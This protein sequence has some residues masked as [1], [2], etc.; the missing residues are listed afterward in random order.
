MHMMVFRY[1]HALNNIMFY[2]KSALFE[3]F[4]S[5]VYAEFGLQY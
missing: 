5:Y 1:V 2:I 4:M 3:G